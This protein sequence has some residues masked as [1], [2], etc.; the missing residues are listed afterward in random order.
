MTPDAAGRAVRDALAA[1]GEDEPEALVAP[2]RQLL[3]DP[4]WVAPLL[5]PWIAALA[6][7]PFAE[8]PLR[9]AR[10]P[11]RTSAV[12]AQGAHAILVASVISAAVLRAR[13]PAT[14]LAVSGR[15][16]V[17]RYHRAGA[18]TLL[19]WGAGDAG[20]AGEAGADFAAADAPPAV[21]LAPRP[22][23]DGAIVTLDGRRRAYLIEGAERD[24]VTLTVAPRAGRAGLTR[25]YDRATG[26]LRRVASN[27]EAGSRARMLLTLLRLSGRIDAAPCFEVA[28]HHAAFHLRW[29]AMREWLALDAAA[30]APRLRTMAATDTNAE[31]R[32]AAAATLP[33]VEARLCRA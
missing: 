25:E 24:V 6:D 19:A 3:A 14:T 2:A 12:L 10:D 4:W 15:V 18:A 28:T 33:M 31:V 20:D 13:P 17:T 8:P 30:A 32:A 26:A 7:D 22:L 16:S 29:A 21:A 23:F 11:L 9:A 27:D 5:A 1:V